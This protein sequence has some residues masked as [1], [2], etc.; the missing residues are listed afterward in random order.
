MNADSYARTTF[1][2]AGSPLNLLAGLLVPY[3]TTPIALT[4]T[5]HTWARP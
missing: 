1:L 4:V 2:P 3:G 5:F